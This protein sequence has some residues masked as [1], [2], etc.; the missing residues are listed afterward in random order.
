MNTVMNSPFDPVADVADVNAAA[1]AGR[2]DAVQNL[3]ARAHNAGM[4]AGLLCRPTP[5]LVGEA[6]S[7][8]STEIDFSKPI[9]R[10]DDG[11]CGFAWINFPGNKPF[12]K[13]MKKLGL[14]RA[15]YPTGQQVWVSEFGQSVERKAAYAGAY[16]KVLKAAGIEDVYAGDRMD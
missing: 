2:V 4:R 9:Y 13:A 14:S 3:V 15:G 1:K 8:V 11:A 6:L 5:M 10:V 7:L 16:A 12:G